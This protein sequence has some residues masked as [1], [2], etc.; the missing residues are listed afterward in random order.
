MLE[1]NAIN[2]SSFGGTSQIEYEYVATIN[3]ATSDWI[4]VPD[5][6]E[7]VIYSVNILSGTGNLQTTLD[8]IENI[9]ANTVDPDLI[10]EW[11][12]SATTGKHNVVSQP[13]KAF[14]V[15]ATG[16]TKIAVKAVAR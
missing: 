11:N 3:N 2:Q 1:M 12:N 6:M 13:I 14:R 10:D 7:R 9:K 8:T 5:N 4:R 16:M 15:V